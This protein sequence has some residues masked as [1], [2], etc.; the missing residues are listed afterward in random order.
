MTEQPVFFITSVIN[1]QEKEL[2]YSKTRSIYSAESRIE[3]TLN[4][5]RS[6]RK[7]IPNALVVLFELG[8]DNTNLVVIQKSVDKYYF[9]GRNIFV[10]LAVNSKHKGLGEAVG[11]LTGSSKFKHEYKNTQNYMFKISGRYFL[12]NNFSLKSW[13]END[14]SV[15]LYGDTISTRLYGFSSNYFKTW[16]KILLTSL[17]KLMQG[18]SIEQVMYKKISKKKHV[19]KTLGVS[20]LVS[21]DGT[22]ISE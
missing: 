10:K 12:N 16:I 15:K 8:F 18:M 13:N 2:S 21:I 5:I 1:Y 14:I 19:V 11:L 20:G 9:L 22:V 7:K 4:T 17:P 6:I 3:Q